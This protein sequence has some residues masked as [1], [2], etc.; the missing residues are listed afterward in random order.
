[1]KDDDGEEECF[2]DQWYFGYKNNKAK[3]SMV[4]QFWR[5]K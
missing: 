5:Q 1:M 3:D 4:L 2:K